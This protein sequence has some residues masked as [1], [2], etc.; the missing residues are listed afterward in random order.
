MTPL[1]AHR[2]VLVFRWETPRVKKAKSIDAKPTW[3]FGKIACVLT[4]PRQSPATCT[5]DCGTRS[6]EP[7][8]F[9]S[10]QH[11]CAEF[12][13]AKVY[14]RDAFD[15]TSVGLVGAFCVFALGVGGTSTAAPRLCQAPRPHW[16]GC[17]PR[18]ALNPSH[19][20][21]IFDLRSHVAIFGGSLK[22]LGVC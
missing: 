10:W 11:L 7:E 15:T 20:S 19:T 22:N 16:S 17:Y 21:G 12:R 4:S 1:K 6:R 5:T 9:S 13:S 18:P 14:H 8:E 3:Y 2:F